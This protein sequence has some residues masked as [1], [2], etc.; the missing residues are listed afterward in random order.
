ML[1]EDTLKLKAEARDWVVLFRRGDSR[2]T[3]VE[4]LVGCGG[5]NN[6]GESSQSRRTLDCIQV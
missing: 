3:G 5:T 6:M 2:E 1:D 4:S